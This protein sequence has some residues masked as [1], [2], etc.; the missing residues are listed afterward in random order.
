MPASITPSSASD[1]RVIRLGTRGSALAL[2]Q[3]ALVIQALHAR[4]PDL[5]IEPVVIRTEGDVDKTSPLTLIGGRGVFTTALQEALARGA[6]DAAVHSA[7]DLPSD[8]PPGLDLVAFPVR[9]DPRDVLI[10]RHGQ[11]LAALPPAPT[12]GTSSRRRAVQVRA[13]RPDVQVIELRGNIDTRL[14]KAIATDVDGIVIAAAG[15]RRMGWADQIVEELPVAIAVPS[16]G[17][18]ALAVEARLADEATVSLLAALDAPTVSTAV[19]VERAFLRAVG[20]GCT[21]PLGAYAEVLDDRRV[22]L[23]AMLASED[24]ERVEWAD[25]TVQAADAE[26]VAAS[27]AVRMLALVRAAGGASFRYHAAPSGIAPLVAGAMHRN[28]N[29]PRPLAGLTI[30]VTRARDQAAPLS[31]A[32]RAAGADPLEL[33]TIR[34]ADPADLAPLDD[35]IRGVA[36]ARYDWVVFT[37]VNGVAQVLARAADLGVGAAA[38]SHARVAAVGDTTAD[39]LRSGGVRVDLMPEQFDAEA[40]VAALVARGI[41]GRRVLYPRADI[42]RGAIP[43]GLRTAGAVVDEVEAY[44][45]LPETIVDPTVRTRVIGGAVDIAT[46]ASG[47]SVRNL[48]ALLGDDFGVLQQTEIACIGPATAA[49]A[50][51]FG[52]T[53]DVVAND[54]TVPGLVA[55][56]VEHRRRH[57]GAVIV[58]NRERERSGVS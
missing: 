35:A 41:A 45:T 24:G 33:P 28:G 27:L 5:T 58:G 3:T 50:R 37:S 47:S 53:V 54:A 40:V 14:R 8:Q 16:P 18:G 21:T 32:L 52:L 30:L 26:S 39:R 57:A 7:K 11:S 9:D 49:V 55:A 56:L 6:I 51:E 38:L 34:F 22:R 36:G 15:V 31:D 13:L 2:A 23:L 4:H 10:S 43:T 12:I 46:F 1:A 20:G 29:G 25:E 42:A 17:Q 44:R 48:A 19:R